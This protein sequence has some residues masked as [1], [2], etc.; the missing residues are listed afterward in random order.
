MVALPGR[1]FDSAVQ[2]VKGLIKAAV[3]GSLAVVDQI[4]KSFNIK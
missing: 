3:K 1:M 2:N 4:K